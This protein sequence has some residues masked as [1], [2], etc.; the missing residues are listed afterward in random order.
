MSCVS[1]QS[2]LILLTKDDPVSLLDHLRSDYKVWWKISLNFLCWT[3]LYQDI[4][5]LGLVY[6]KIYFP[7]WRLIYCQNPNLSST[8]RLGFTWKWL[9]TTTTTTHSPPPTTT[10]YRNSQLLLTQFWWN[11]KGWFLGISRTGTICHS[12]MGHWLEEVDAHWKLHGTFLK[13]SPF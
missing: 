13:S 10:Q 11:S 4:R 7:Y 3:L 2:L 8:Q 12:D 5:V 6:C 1:W 9:Y